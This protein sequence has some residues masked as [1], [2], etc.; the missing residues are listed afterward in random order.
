MMGALL[1]WAL[2]VGLLQGFLHCTGMCGPFVLAF[3]M[4]YRN[5]SAQAVHPPKYVIQSHLAHN[6][7][8]ILSF[9]I[10][11]AI[12]GALGHF[13][14]TAGHATGLDAAAGILGGGMMI[15]WAL[16][17]LKT[18]H[19]G[20]FME[21]WSLLQWGPIKKTFRKLMTIRSPRAAFIAGL[22]LGIHPCGLIF[23]MLL[24]AAAT[25]SPLSGALILLV[26]GIGTSP[27]LLSVAIAGWYGSKRLQGRKFSYIAAGLIALSGIIFMLRGLAVNG[28]IP[29]VN[30]WLF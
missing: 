3:S 7:G 1:L 15:L 28:W 19:G 12:F 10:M 6:L 11:G 2:G 5:Q 27:A 4:S 18:G 16:D 17:E 29:E 20:G 26:F 21:K 23:A 24:S 25:A 30:P 9:T 14:N 8:R 13:V 22:I